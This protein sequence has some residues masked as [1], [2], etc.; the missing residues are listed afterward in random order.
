MAR[1]HTKQL[2]LLEAEQVKPETQPLFS[3]WAYDLP[4][5]E[6]Y[7]ELRRKQGQFELTEEQKRASAEYQEQRA[8]DSS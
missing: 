5:E 3:D 8:A 2:G 7:A 6:A 4:D 1:Q